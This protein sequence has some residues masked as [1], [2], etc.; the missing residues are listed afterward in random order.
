MRASLR[1]FVS[2]SEKGSSPPYMFEHTPETP[3]ESL[4]LLDRLKPTGKFLFRSTPLWSGSEQP[5]S[6]MFFRFCR[7]FSWSM[8]KT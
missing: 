5:E 8:E 3:S 7:Y 1:V 4:P 6:A 2:G